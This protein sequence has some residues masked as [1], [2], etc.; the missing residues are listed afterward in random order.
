VQEVHLAAALELAQ[1]RLADQPFGERR[2]EGLDREALSPAR[3]R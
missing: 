3:W 1:G 2:D